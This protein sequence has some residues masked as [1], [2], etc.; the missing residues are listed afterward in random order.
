MPISHNQGG[1]VHSSFTFFF[2]C[3]NALCGLAQFRFEPRSKKH[4]SRKALCKSH[5]Y[6]VLY[7]LSNTSH[8]IHKHQSEFY[9]IT[10]QLLSKYDKLKGKN[11]E[12]NKEMFM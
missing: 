6:A 1:S 11:R 8:F 10:H 3:S 7:I 2:F 5:V 9:E 12:N 4:K